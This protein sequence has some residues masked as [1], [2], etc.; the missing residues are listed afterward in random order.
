MSV[1]AAKAPATAAVAKASAPA[2]KAPAPKA[3]SKPAS[4]PMAI[5]SLPDNSKS[6]SDAE[7]EV[8]LTASVSGKTYSVPYIL[9]G[10]QQFY[11]EQGKPWSRLDYDQAQKTCNG[12]GMELLSEDDWQTILDSKVMEQKDW[13]MHLPYW[14]AQKKRA[15]YQWQCYST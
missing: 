13:P 2:P 5:Q 4:E 14:G 9:D 7:V 11:M 10:K 3:V 6:S 15:V 1:T 8:R 12:L